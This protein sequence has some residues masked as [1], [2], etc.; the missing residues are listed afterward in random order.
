MKTVAGKWSKGQWINGASKAELEKKHATWC[1]NLSRCVDCREEEDDEEEKEEAVEMGGGGGIV[2]VEQHRVQHSWYQNAFIFASRKWSSAPPRSIAYAA[3]AT[4]SAD[5]TGS[6]STPNTSNK[7]SM[8]AAEKERVLEQWAAG[9]REEKR[10]RRL[11]KRNE[12]DQADAEAK[13]KERQS[14]DVL[15]TRIEVNG[16]SQVELKYQVMVDRLMLFR[17]MRVHGSRS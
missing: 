15:R 1:D 13:R 9:K 16:A 10:L 14:T 8:S 11:A 2:T 7:I 12:G 5:S 17:G 6:S 3:P 4:Y